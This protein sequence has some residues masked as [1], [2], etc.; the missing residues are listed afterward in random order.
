MYPLQSFRSNVYDLTIT[1][2]SSIAPKRPKTDS[3]DTVFSANNA[4]PLSDKIRE[5]EDKR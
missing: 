2:Q 4:I 1:I 5:M 3:K